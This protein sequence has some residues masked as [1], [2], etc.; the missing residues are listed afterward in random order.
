MK[1]KFYLGIAAFMLACAT[2]AC[3]SDDPAPDNGT[4]IVDNG[5]KV[6]MDLNIT[7][8]SPNGSR[9]ST[10]DKDDEDVS[11]DGT[12]IGQTAE[13]TVSNVMVLL[14]GADE[15]GKDIC[16]IAKWADAID[17]TEITAAT[18]I[19]AKFQRSALL[20]HYKLHNI[21]NVNVYVICNYTTDIDAS[22]GQ[23]GINANLNWLD[24]VIKTTNAK[25]IPY[26]ENRKFL[27]TNS[28]KYQSTIPTE[29][30]INNGK[31]GD[32]NNK[33]P[34]ASAAKPITV[35]R[36]VARFDYAAKIDGSKVQG[37]GTTV[38]PYYYVIAEAKTGDKNN[39]SQP[40]IRTKLHRMALVNMS[41]DFY[42]FR[43]VSDDGTP[44]GANFMIGGRE[45]MT[46]NGDANYVVSPGYDFKKN[47]AGKDEK[48]DYDPY[49]YYWVNDYD[50]S[51]SGVIS[52]TRWDGVNIEEVLN[53]TKYDG[54][55][56]YWRYVLPNTIPAG[57]NNQ[58]AFISTGV[59]FK[60][61]IY[62]ADETIGVGRRMADQFDIFAYQGQLIGS[63]SDVRAYAK[64][65]PE[66]GIAIAYKNAV[67]KDSSLDTEE[68][69]TEDTW[70]T[71]TKTQ[72]KA[73]VKTAGF[74]KYGYV[75]DG[76][77]GHGGYFCYYYYW[78]RHNNNNQNDIMGPMEF[79]VVRNNVYKLAV[80]NIKRLGHPFRPGNHPDPFD[81]DTPDEEAELFMELHVQVLPW[82]VRVNN[83]EF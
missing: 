59:V 18:P 80:T 82:T 65:V 25:N 11:T 1:T 58:K 16:F 13:N 21:S 7:V 55:Y 64:A 3:S 10:T 30:D 77:D 57:P 19:T 23:A 73:A 24:E 83:I 81:P 51:E 39:E 37:D 79:A 45:Y 2:T 60:A 54:K 41:K 14:V 33:F 15:Y 50:I 63:W 44:T 5:E 68:Q 69:I 72:T 75:A 49:F 74:A 6:Y 26:W 43:R 76:G 29:S 34:L 28:T 66:S 38:N 56:S 78:N 42:L 61:E 17:P 31:Y 9:S 12:E 8:P 71:L 53:Q 67:E 35:E 40:E 27:M 22:I 4:E 47:I 62:A 46:S 52:N 70:K 20:N 36:A 32:E 48:E